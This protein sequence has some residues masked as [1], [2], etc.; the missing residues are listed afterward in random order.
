M[1]NRTLVVLHVALALFDGGL[2]SAHHSFAPMFDGERHVRLR[3]VVARFELVNPHSFIVVDVAGA[4]G[5]T[6][7]WA[8]EGPS[9]R[10]L[11]RRGYT[12]A[13]IKPGEIVEACGYLTRDPAP[14]LDPKTGVFRRVMNVELLTLSN[15]TPR[16]WQDYGLRR[17][18]D[19]P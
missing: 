4:D 2:L 17:C 10:G 3:G 13:S 18:R 1:A 19:A 7:Q 16:L 14:R 12:E 11:A 5:R 8:L 9:V 6:E 15:G